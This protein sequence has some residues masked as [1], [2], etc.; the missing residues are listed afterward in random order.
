VTRQPLWDRWQDLRT[1]A[2]IGSDV[3]F[4]DL[5]GTAATFALAAGVTPTEGARSPGHD[6]AD[7]M[8]TYVGAIPGGHGLVADAIGRARE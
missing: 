5:R 4:H 1:R 6:P 3:R 2:G 7:L 8:R